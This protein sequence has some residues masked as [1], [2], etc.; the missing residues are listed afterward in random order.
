MILMIYEN[1]KGQRNWVKFPN[2]E[3]LNDFYETE[4]ININTVKI[5]EI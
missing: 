1:N 3:I 5:F 4:D 2:K